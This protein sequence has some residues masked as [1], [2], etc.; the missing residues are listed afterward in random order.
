MSSSEKFSLKW[1]DFKDNVSSAFQDLRHDINF[2]DVTLVGE[3]KQHITAHKVVLAIASPF[4][5]E[6]LSNSKNSHPFIYMR[7]ISDKYLTAIVNFIYYGEVNSYHVQLLNLEKLFAI[8]I[9][10][11][12][13]IHMTMTG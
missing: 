11:Y 5:R 2:S 13:Y 4:F 1:N 3:G 9:F 6:M 10:R 12:F 7:G 8:L